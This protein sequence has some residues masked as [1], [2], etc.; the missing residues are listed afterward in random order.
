MSGLPGANKKTTY[1]RKLARQRQLEMMEAAASGSAPTMELSMSSF[2]ESDGNFLRSRTP[3]ESSASIDTAIHQT[4]INNVGNNNN[5]KASSMQSNNLFARPETTLTS[6]NLMDHS[7]GIYQEQKGGFLNKFKNLMLARTGT[8]KND[9]S[10]AMSG[11]NNDNYNYNDDYIG[12]V[13]QRRPV[14]GPSRVNIVTAKVKSVFGSR[15]RVLMLLAATGAMCVVIFA[16]TRIGGGGGQAMSEKILRAQHSENFNAI[17]DHI[18]AEGVSASSVFL[19]SETP[20]FHALRWI[21]YSD[22]AALA[23]SDPMVLQRYALAVFFYAS[24]LEFQTV[25]GAQ[26][27]IENEDEQYEGVPNPGWTRKDYWLTDKGVCSWYGIHCP[28]REVNGVTVTRYDDN[29]PIIGLNLTSNRMYGTMPPEFKGLHGSLEFIDFSDNR[30]H[31]SMPR[32]MGGLYLLKQL[33]LY[34]NDM[35]GQLPPELG[36]LESAEELRL[37][38]NKFSGTIP[39]ELSRLYSVRS[40]SLDHNAITGFVPDLNNC[41]KLRHLYLND[42]LLD[43][44]FPFVIA[45]LSGLNELELQNNKLSGTIPPEV[46]SLRFIDNFQVQ[47]NLISGSIP[48][49]IFGKLTHLKTLNLQQNKFRGRMPTQIGMLRK[50]QELRLNDNNLGGDFPT[51]WGRL[52]TLEILHIFNNKVGGAIP[53]Q[54]GQMV[55]LKEFHAQNNEF[56]HL[57]T[58]MGKMEDL[59]N[60]YLEFNKFGGKVPAEFGQLEQLETLKINHNLFTGSVPGDICTLKKQNALRFL[61]ADCNNRIDCECCDKCY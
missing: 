30:M 27:P 28:P 38:H 15:N 17:F 1:E 10:P 8:E 18:L 36:F 51:E 11:G 55:E 25:A 14:K 4:N 59:K 44:K 3:T 54:I 34:R 19:S 41:R 33:F 2:A 61:E 40:I 26:A 12:D 20:E 29:V 9:A 58:E 50:L 5:R 21:S 31:G 13:Y 49:H 60:L 57:P 22:T 37:G 35:T 52:S 56:N 47:N 45:K 23:P 32:E 24:Y 7:T 42:N 48:A 6:L 16:S 53:T 46:E 39:S 43:G